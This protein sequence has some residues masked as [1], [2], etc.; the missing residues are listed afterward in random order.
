MTRGT[1]IR[2][3]TDVP[4]PGR[5]VGG[6]CLILGPVLLLT[7]ALLRVQFHFFAP[8]QLQAF[9][10]HP[11]L[12]TAAYS[13]HSAGAVAL[14][15]G[16]LVLVHRIAAWNRTWAFWGGAFAVVGLFNRI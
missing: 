9:E 10:A 11:H 4:F 1:E 13:T 7:G 3:G 12:V 16:I 14:C 5:W 2:D 8:Q 6:V 15:F